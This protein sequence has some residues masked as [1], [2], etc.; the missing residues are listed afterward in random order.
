MYKVNPLFKFPVAFFPLATFAGFLG[1]S[2]NGI[3][4]YYFGP[5]IKETF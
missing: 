3:Y 2:N 1:F 4:F 5:E